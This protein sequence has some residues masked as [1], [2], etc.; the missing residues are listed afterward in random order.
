MVL[1]RIPAEGA[2]ALGDILIFKSQQNIKR[3]DC[4]DFEEKCSIEN[5]EILKALIKKK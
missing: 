5:N 2:I 1:P 4:Y 3:L